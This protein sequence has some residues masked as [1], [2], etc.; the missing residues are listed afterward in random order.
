VEY[1]GIRGVIL[2]KMMKYTMSLGAVIL[3]LLFIYTS[4]GTALL[5]E[6]ST[7]NLINGADYILIGDVV[8]VQI[9]GN[10]S[11]YTQSATIS[12]VQSL[13]GTPTNPVVVLTKGMELGRYEAVFFPGERVMIFLRFI[14]SDLRV[15]GGSQGEILLEPTQL[16]PEDLSLDDFVNVLR[17]M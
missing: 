4:I 1:L 5:I 10:P 7:E 8:D 11:D 6:L 9:V 14:G 2:G 16:K 3:A 17:G 12:L 13:K 15:V